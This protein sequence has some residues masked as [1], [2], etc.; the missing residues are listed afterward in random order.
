MSSDTNWVTTLRINLF[1]SDD[2]INRT[3]W[4]PTEWE[5]IFTNFTSESS[6]NLVCQPV[7]DEGCGEVN[8]GTGVTSHQEVLKKIN[9]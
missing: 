8:A 7:W 1:A 2:T 6:P 3:K 5:K 9:A 4:Q